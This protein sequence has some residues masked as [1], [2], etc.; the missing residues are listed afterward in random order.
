MTPFKAVRLLFA[1]LIVPANSWA[2]A[3]APRTGLQ[4]CG[5]A[6]VPFEISSDL[7]LRT[8]VYR[9]AR[10]CSNGLCEVCEAETINEKQ[11]T[12]CKARL[13]VN[14]LGV[15]LRYNKVAAPVSTVIDQPGGA[16]FVGEPGTSRAVYYKRGFRFVEMIWAAGISIKDGV[17]AIASGSGSL[18]ENVET[19]AHKNLA[20]MWMKYETA[21]WTVKDTS[22]R[23]AKVIQFVNQKLRGK[24]KFIGTGCSA[25][26][27]LLSAAQAFHNLDEVLDYAVWVGNP[28]NFDLPYFC[29]GSPQGTEHRNFSSPHS[30]GQVYNADAYR[31]NPVYMAGL[32]PI[33]DYVYA[34][35]GA[36]VAG[37]NLA[38]FREGSPAYDAGADL[39]FSTP[40]DTVFGSP[41]LVCDVTGDGIADPV[42]IADKSSLGTAKSFDGPDN[43]KRDQNGVAILDAAGKYIL[44]PLTTCQCGM[45]GVSDLKNCVTSDKKITK[46]AAKNGQPA[47]YY[48]EL[49]GYP[50][51]NSDIHK[52][53]VAQT[54]AYK[55]AL[56][57]SRSRKV[58]FYE[59]G[60]NHCGGPTAVKACELIC[61]QA[62]VSCPCDEMWMVTLGN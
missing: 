44:E 4:V 21:P 36:C 15:T 51:N 40:V 1:L 33:I 61:R 9:C 13:V 18:L 11:Y 17:E 50:V 47:Y 27:F 60:A 24:E 62:G 48:L 3:S 53:P 56:D 41:A 38:V 20:G 16:G 5:N 29:G 10:S 46:V 39:A 6:P 52:G 54:L 58:G 28:G 8:S 23:H 26:A 57:A 49:R 30:S 37:K 7:Q 22:E 25:G 31:A 34:S 12:V 43:V 55:D 14:D 2:A 42:D 19:V 59:V 45:P 32:P 35:G